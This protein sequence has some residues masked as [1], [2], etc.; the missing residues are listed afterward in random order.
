[1]TI[2]F[3]L[4]ACIIAGGLCCSY[5][6]RKILLVGDTIAFSSQVHMFGFTNVVKSIIFSECSNTTLV[7]ESRKYWNSMTLMNDISEMLNLHNPTHVIFM[8]ATSDAVDAQLKLD[9]EDSTLDYDKILNNFHSNFE[10]L[11]STALSRNIGVTICSPL[12]IGEV[13]N[14]RHDEVIEEI[15]G[16]LLHVAVDYHVE[17]IDIRSVLINEIE[18]R[19]IENLNSHIVTYDGMHLNEVGNKIVADCLL[20]GYFGFDQSSFKHANYNL[21]HDCSKESEV[22]LKDFRGRRNDVLSLSSLHDKRTLAF[23]KE[24]HLHAEK[25]VDNQIKKAAP[26]STVAGV[27]PNSRDKLESIDEIT[28]NEL[29]HMKP[30]TPIT[31]FVVYV[32]D[33]NHSETDKGSTTSTTTSPIQSNMNDDEL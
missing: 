13:L 25:Y 21:V 29:L 11:V 23:A 3:L 2:L 24:R 5:T 17:F 33:V 22:M 30:H 32:D 19:N 28:L 4:L 6:N 27:T 14:N 7:I 18:N 10:Y 26:T 8:F 16:Y 20:S 9:S 31:N 1:M 12:V 15:M